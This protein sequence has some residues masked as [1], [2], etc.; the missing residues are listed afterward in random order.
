VDFEWD[1]AKRQ[2]A[3]AKHG[4]DPLYAAR[5]FER[6]TFEVV[7]DRQDYG[8]V[9]YRALG[10]VRDDCFVLIYTKRGD[11]VRLITAWKGGRD[12][13]D[14]YE[15]SLAARDRRDGS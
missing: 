10:M 13:R 14:S 8:E 9:R 15:A 3:I 1:E 7:D 2:Q 12:D 4:V 11:L 6:I 5:M